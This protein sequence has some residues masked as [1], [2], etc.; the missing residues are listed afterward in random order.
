[1]IK[2]NMDDTNA[3]ITKHWNTLEY[4]YLKRTVSRSLDTLGVKSRLLVKKPKLTAAMQQK[5]FL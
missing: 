4:H 3:T 5:R 1:M 2:E